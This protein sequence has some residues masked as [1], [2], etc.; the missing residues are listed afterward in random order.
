MVTKTHATEKSRSVAWASAR[1]AKP[2]FPPAP[3]T[4]CLCQAATS[5]YYCYIHCTY[6]ACSGQPIPLCVPPHGQDR[7]QA[8]TLPRDCTPFWHTL[9][10][11]HS[12]KPSSLRFASILSSS[13]T[14]PAPRPAHTVSPILSIIVPDARTTLSLPAYPIVGAH[15]D[16][17][18]A[19]V[20]D[21]SV[22]RSMYARAHRV[23]AAAAAASSL[24]GLHA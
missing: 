24:Q 13:W 6:Y 12:L 11:L 23:A 21:A 2:G 1:A 18:A 20:H 16:T 10:S 15:N 7:V 14:H 5:T 17:D 8:L 4:R 9:A 19:P 22:I 3:T